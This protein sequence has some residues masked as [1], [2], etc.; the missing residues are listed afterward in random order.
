MVLTR[1]ILYSSWYGWKL[2]TLFKFARLCL[3]LHKYVTCVPEW[4]NLRETHLLY[5]FESRFGGG[6]LH[7]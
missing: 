4:K 1:L 7:W 6:V 5:S 2:G 3:W